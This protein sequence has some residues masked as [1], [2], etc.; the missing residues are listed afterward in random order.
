MKTIQ[1]SDTM[2]QAFV[3]TAQDM[4][5]TLREGQPTRAELASTF[6]DPGL[7]QVARRT[8]EETEKEIELL[9]AF[10]QEHAKPCK[11]LPSGFMG[12]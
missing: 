2:L 11:Q 6:S 12:K 4:L 8:A 5:V 3:E 10:I 9:E 1:V 7:A